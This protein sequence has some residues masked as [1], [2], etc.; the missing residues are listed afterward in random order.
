MKLYEA[1]VLGRERFGEHVLLRYRWNGNPPEPGQFV[2]ARATTQDLNPFLSRPL[3]AH[4]YDKGVASLLFR[5]SGAGTALLAQES[6]GILVTTPGGRG[7]TF[8][9]GDRLVALIGGGVWVSPLK[10]LSRRLTLSGVAHDVYLEV[11]ATAPKAYAAWISENYSHAILVPTDGSPQASWT[12]LDY[13]GDLAR[14]CALYASGPA[15]MLDAVRIASAG[16]VSA[17][18]ALRERM[19]CANGSCFGCAIPVWR[20]GART[21]ARACTEGPVFAVETLAW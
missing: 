2:M 9:E 1:E 3:F 20:S 13:L 10:L 11:P 12:V 6:T 7:Y 21:Y 17:Q 14:Y 16:K 15:E 4:D 8:E 19:A 5:V 18:V